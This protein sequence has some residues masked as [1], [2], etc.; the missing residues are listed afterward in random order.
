ML[1]HFWVS[2]LTRIH[3]KPPKVMPCLTSGPYSGQNTQQTFQGNALSQLGQYFS[4]NMVRVYLFWFY[5]GKIIFLFIPQTV[6]A[7]LPWMTNNN[8][9]QIVQISSIL[10]Y[11]GL[12]KFS[13]YCA[14]KAASLSFAETLYH[15][16]RDQKKTGVTVTCVCPFHMN[17]SMGTGV[18]SPL[19]CLDPEYVSERVIQAIEEKQFIVIIPRLMYLFVFLKR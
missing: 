8:Y 16:L 15:E 3:N 9:G 6:K 5:L 12:P 11:N 14:S 7:F 2:T 1:Y 10:A 18:T 19:P 17:T 4:Q 13:D